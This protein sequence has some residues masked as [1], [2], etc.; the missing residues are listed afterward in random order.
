VRNIVGPGRF[1]CLPFTDYCWPLLSSP[2][3]AE[4]IHQILT[5]MKRNANRTHAEV[6]GGEWLPRMIERK[7]Y[8][9]FSVDLNRGL[10]EVWRQASEKSIRYSVK[11]AE[12]EGIVIIQGETERELKQ[13]YQLNILTRRY[14]GVIPQPYRFFQNLHK[15]IFSKKRGFLWLAKKDGLAT[16]GSIFL[17]HKDTIYHKYNASHPRYKHLCST[18]LIIWHAIRWAIEH[19][20]KTMDLGRTAPD[21]GGLM[22]FKRHWGAVEADLPYYYHPGPCGIAAG[23][24]KAEQYRNIKTIVHHAPSI[25]L[26]GVGSVFYRFLA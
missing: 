18:H 4:N 14:H 11:K 12:R 25:V 2:R 5:L 21:N 22:S 23:G 7:Y 16:A 19:G 3:D 15:E 17:I 13:F 9:R 1:V 6:R 24:E 8:K 10:D 26:S 20:F